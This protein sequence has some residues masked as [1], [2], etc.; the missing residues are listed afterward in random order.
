MKSQRI[1]VSESWFLLYPLCIAVTAL[2]IFVTWSWVPDPF[3]IHYNV[4]FEADSFLPKEPL[5]LLPLFLIQC[6][7]ALM[8]V[9][10]HYIAKRAPVE[11]IVQFSS[12]LTSE[13]ERIV[14]LNLSRYSIITGVFAVIWIGMLGILTITQN[15]NMPAFIAL[16]AF[17]MFVIIGGIILLLKKDP[18]LLRTNSD[19]VVEEEK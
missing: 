10:L 2:G 4:A 1:V 14:R 3:P 13:R 9:I 16:T 15:L 8:F 7:I 19:I 12:K 5:S 11:H 18:E 17:F 6:G